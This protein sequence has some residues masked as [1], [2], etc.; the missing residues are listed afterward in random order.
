MDPRLLSY[1]DREL[2]YVREMGAEFAR[3]FPKIA[4][5]LG[6]SAQDVSSAPTPT[7]SGCWKGSRF[8]RRASS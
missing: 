7:S 3:E 1:Y 5:R 6:L 8:S 2:Q 4:R